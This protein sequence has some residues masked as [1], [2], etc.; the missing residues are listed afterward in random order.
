[1]ADQGIALFKSGVHNLLDEEIIPTDAASNSNN[2]YTKNGRISLIPGKVSIGSTGVAGKI[3]GEIFGYKVNGTKVHWRK[4]GTKIQYF[5]GTTWQDTITGLTSSADYTFSNY[6]SLAGA[7]TFAFGVDGIYKMNNANPGSYCSM[8]NSAKNFKGFGTIDKGRTLLWNRVEDKTGLYGSYIDRQNSTVYTSVSGEATTSLSG[9]LAFKSG[10]ATRNCFGVT[11]TLTVSGEVYTDNYLGA[12]S[13]SLG[14]TGTINY[15]TGAYT[16]SNAGVGTAAYQ[17]EDSNAKGVTD[18]THTATR[19]AGEGF[20]IPQDEGGDAIL[21]V[22]IGPNDT[23]YSMKKQSVY[24]LAISDDDLTVT[25]NVFRR[26]LGI[27]SFR[28]AISMQ[29]GIVFMNSAKHELPELTILERNPLGGDVLPK[30]F[31][32]HF[33]FANYDY[34]DCTIDT[35][36]K[37]ILVA[38]KSIGATNND[39]ILLCDAENK[40]VDITSYAARTFA[41][42]SGNL[43]CGS[44]ITETIYN[45]YNGWDDDGSNIDNIWTGKGELWKSENLKKYRKI[46]L[47]GNISADQSY[48]ISINYD[49]AG[50]QVVG[51]VLGSGSYVDYTSPQTVGSNIIGSA[52][53]GGDDIGETYPYFIEIRL[54]KVPKFRKRQISYRALGIGYVD[55]N[56]HLDLGIETYEGKIP[57]RFRQKQNVSIDGA[58]ENLDNPDY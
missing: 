58:T 20:Q 16:V 46:R 31:F 12:L 1:M 26:E 24:Q 28:A 42:D 18:F 11:I 47:M 37:Y 8:Y 13:G 35:Y 40:T 36:D 23:Y 22:V 45:L 44:S 30:V 52:Q 21:N 39:T 10:G 3:T 4:A 27:L 5:D 17:W 15:I 41:K 9:T 33:Q 7:F 34:S 55:I 2:W 49:G 56:S 25:N 29:L 57:T 19:L 50:S 14:G 38:C 48:E 51:T 53:V 54:K 32:Q 43:Y 6:S